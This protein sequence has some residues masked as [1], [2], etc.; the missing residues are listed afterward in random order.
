[1]FY[2]FYAKHTRSWYTSQILFQR[3]LFVA[4]QLIVARNSNIHKRP[5]AR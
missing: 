2:I 5:D 1:M 4:V 3:S